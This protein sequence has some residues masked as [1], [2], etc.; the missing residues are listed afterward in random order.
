MFYERPIYRPLGDLFLAVEFGDELHLSLNFMVI[1]LDLSLRDRP[2]PGVT[3]TIPTNRSLMVAYDSVVLRQAH[4]IAALRER[5]SEITGLRRVPSRIVSIPIWYNDKWS[6]ECA[7]AHGMPNNMEYLAEINQ[8]TVEGVITAHS[9]TDWWVSSVGFQPG[10]FQALPLDPGFSV[11]APK[12]PRPRE[13]TPERIL[14]LAGKIT[15][16]YPVRSPGGYQLLGRTPIELY[17]PLQRNV[18]FRDSPVLPI[19][20]ERHQYVPIEEAEY[21]DIR[22]Q[23][24]LGAYE[25][26]IE[27]GHYSLDEYRAR[28]GTVET[29]RAV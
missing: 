18:V 1:A 6:E 17:D 2:I 27:E 26:E 12:Y 24:E 9:E 29:A 11:T 21:H 7:R 20:S 8:T 23:V 15:S 13:W 5:E 10:T 14:C 28:E 25:F 4:L 22:R 16:F 3:E 19:V